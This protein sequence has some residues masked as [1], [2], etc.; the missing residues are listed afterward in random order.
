MCAFNILVMD[1]FF[2]WKGIF[3]DFNYNISFMILKLC[4][5]AH[6]ADSGFQYGGPTKVTQNIQNKTALQPLASPW[7]EFFSISLGFSV[8]FAK[9]SLGV[10]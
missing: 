10:S 2:W 6:F 3:N 7:S 4:E 5:I 1:S 8:T 9:L